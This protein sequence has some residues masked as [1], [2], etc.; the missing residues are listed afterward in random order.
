[1]KRGC[2]SEG[3]EQGE[4]RRLKEKKYSRKWLNLQVNNAEGLLVGPE[5]TLKRKKHMLGS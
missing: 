2:S 3:K 5:T 4:K 1:L